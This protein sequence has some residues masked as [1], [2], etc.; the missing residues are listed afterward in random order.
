MFVCES[1]P[2]VMT[3]VRRGKLSPV[4]WPTA[5][6]AV[7]KER[8]YAAQVYMVYEQIR[9]GLWAGGDVTRLPGVCGI[10]G[11]RTVVHEN[12]PEQ[13]RYVRAHH[14]DRRIPEDPLPLPSPHPQ[15]SL[16]P[17]PHQ[18]KLLNEAV[19]QSD[20]ITTPPHQYYIHYYFFIGHTLI[21]LIIVDEGQSTDEPFSR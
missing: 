10:L 1:F 13:Q 12:T 9:T 8:L 18:I 7:P 19:G 15:C 5:L 4:P 17:R 2:I 3:K 21:Y 11:R 16:R 6:A 14:I 20:I